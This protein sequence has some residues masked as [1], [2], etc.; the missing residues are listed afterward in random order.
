[1]III[2]LIISSIMEGVTIKVIKI[3]QLLYRFEPC[4]VNSLA[5][6]LELLKQKKNISNSNVQGVPQFFNN[7][8]IFPTW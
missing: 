2:I 5:P 1:M 4:R 7:N 8:R 6:K 3:P